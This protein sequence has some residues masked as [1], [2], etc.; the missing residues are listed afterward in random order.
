MKIY[1]IKI[2]PSE[3]YKT[4]RRSNYYIIFLCKIILFRRRIRRFI[5][6][7]LNDSKIML[8]LF[9][10]LWFLY[11]LLFLIDSSLFFKDNTLTINL[12]NYFIYIW[13]KKDVFITSIITVFFINTGM[14]IYRRKEYLNKRF[15]IC[16]NI[17]M[18]FN[19]F[20]S[21]LGLECDY[22]INIADTNCK[23][24]MGLIP[25]KE[26]KNISNL[27]TTHKNNILYIIQNNYIV[28]E[29]GG[30]ISYI[31]EGYTLSEIN[32]IFLKNKSNSEKIEI[33]INNYIQ[34]YY[35]YH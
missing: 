29:T 4:T 33:I 30:D 16:T 12:K 21:S 3:E 22:W 5:E 6:R 2:N 1:K 23:E 27:L 31:D 10:F 13:Q 25:D 18:Y 26:N 28:K 8:Y 7:N 14:N 17:H 32:S 34:L 19:D 15:D 35:Y 11:T 9:I 24:L 20:L